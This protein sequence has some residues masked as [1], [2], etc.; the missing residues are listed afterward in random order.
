MELIC[1]TGADRRRYNIPVANE[2]AMIIPD[3]YG[4]ASVRHIVFAHRKRV[5]ESEYQVISSSHAAYTPLHYTLLFPYGEHGWHW[6]LQ[7]QQSQE[8]DGSRI[9]LTQ[10]QYNQFRLYPRL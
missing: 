10:H 3:K 4:I 8:R 9:C 2:V 1:A 6:A 7:V 5:N